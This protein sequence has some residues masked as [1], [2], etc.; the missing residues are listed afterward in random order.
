MTENGDR[1]KPV[2]SIKDPASNSQ[3]PETAN[4]RTDIGSRFSDLIETAEK[5][6]KTTADTHQKFLEFSNELNQGYSKTF[7]LQTKLLEHVIQQPE[8]SIPPSLRGVGPYGPEA[9]FSIPH[10]AFQIPPSDPAFS[11]KDCLEFATGSVARVLGPEFA[12]VDAYP[13]R[14]RLPDEPLML[15]DRILSVEG[16][17]GS[18]GPGRIVTEHDVLPGAWYLDGGH[19]PV[20]IT[21]E[22]GQAD[23]F[24]CAYLG[25]DLAVKGKRT[26]RLLDAAVKFHREMPLPGETIRYEIEISKFIRQGETYLFL[27]SFNG[28][29]GDTPL[30]TMTD[31]CA[32]FFTAE[33]V[34]NSGGIILTG[35][36]TGPVSGKKPSDWKPLVTLNK[37]RYDDSALEALRTGNAAGCFGKDF[38]GITLPGS[39]R[40]PGGRMKLIDRII[41]LDPVGGRYGLGLIQAEA[42]IHA[43]D[44]FLTCHFVDDR[45]MPGTLMYECC[46]H[47]LRV[48]M[49]RM[50]WVTD[51]P[52]A[53]YEPVVGVPSILKCRGPVT[54]ETRRV[55]YEVEIKE[56]GYG[57]Q[58]Y[59][60]AD[61]NM[62]ADGDRIVRFKNMSIQMS[63]ITRKEIE[64]LWDRKS[65]KT[66]R[67]DLPMKRAAVFERSHIL[68]IAV[69]SPSKAFGERYKPF[70]RDRFIARLPGPPF[71][72]I[73]RITRVEPE[74]WVVKPNGWI[75]AEYD[76]SPDAWYFRAEGAPAAPLSI[77]L[78]IALQPCGWLAAYLGSALKSKKDL[79]FRNLGGRATLYRE[80]SPDLKTVSVKT[81]LTK[82][83]EA[84]DMIIEHF[85]FEVWHRDQHIYAGNTYF[86][87]FTIE[88]LAVQEGI[89]DVD[90]HAV[91]PTR[92]E[93][94]D[95]QTHE[96]SDRAPL[97]PRDPERVATRGLTLPARAIRMI[98]RI[99][100]YIPDGGPMGLGFIRATKIV[101]PREWFFDAHFYQ[102]PVLPGSLGIE[103]FI[104]VLKYIALQR[105]PHLIDSHRFGLRTGTSHDW[106]YRG[107]ILPKNRLITVEAVVT[108]V[109]EHPFPTITAEGYLQVDGLYIYKMENFGINLVKI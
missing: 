5:I 24:L 47:T 87:F 60:I 67:P 17:K 10:S 89:R 69:G 70:D 30:I 19:A 66:G 11:R 72:F 21:V 2:S 12:A 76:V 52:G 28:F 81:R 100:A 78:E 15:V 38:A 31:G 109:K 8:A 58:P 1:K 36:D 55:V 14:V 42:D 6:S 83:A 18:L 16:Q 93:I 77:I 79:R 27:F 101:D 48:L 34:K 13:A 92:A 82:A 41:N 37:E 29:I 95:S 23:L 61:A 35:D 39:L 80:L 73:D 74:P 84:G 63:G 62:Y 46:A 40:L 7:A 44:W 45:V 65:K 26:Y 53:F 97:S 20:C 75:E 71:M 68:E 57:P 3:H 25:I 51:K 90:P 22:A 106:V 9:D 98:D 102:D 99:E 4:R 103:S 49:Q 94:L 43:D 105:W 88:T 85:D 96:F 32:G 54:P 107:Q 64:D 56:F 50:G 104:Q 91:I 108:E 86:G 33:E 59:V